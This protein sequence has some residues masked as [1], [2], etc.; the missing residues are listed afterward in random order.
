MANYD[1][2]I[3]R[4]RDYVLNRN[5]AK[6][7]EEEL[8]ALED[9]VLPYEEAPLEGSGSGTDPY[10]AQSVLTGSEEAS[11]QSTSSG[12]GNRPDDNQSREGDFQHNQT[13][14]A[15]PADIPDG[16]DDDVVAR[17]IREAAMKESDPELR[18]K[19]WQEYRKYKN[20]P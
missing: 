16:S 20:Q 8:D 7:S 2:M 10:Q 14:N 19:L 15:P 3:L 6:G 1:G 12:G 4:E 17:Q 18:E 11:Q 5:N 9:G 13:Q